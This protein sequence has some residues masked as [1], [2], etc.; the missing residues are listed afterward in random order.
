[1]FNRCV[2][3]RNGSLTRHRQQALTDRCSDKC[4]NL[5][6]SYTNGP[7]SRA[8][9]KR[10]LTTALALILFLISNFLTLPA[11]A[12]P[13][14]IS[15]EPLPTTDEEIQALHLAFRGYVSISFPVDP[16]IACQ[17]TE[18]SFFE[19]RFTSFARSWFEVTVITQC[20]KNEAESFKVWFQCIELPMR[21]PRAVVCERSVTP[22]ELQF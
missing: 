10:P 6:N 22:T 17:V 14:K 1:M 2:A 5:E 16:N 18:G 4:T 7:A 19:K 20:G 3:I 8:E 12:D 21:G 15:N 9:K 13:P 11:H